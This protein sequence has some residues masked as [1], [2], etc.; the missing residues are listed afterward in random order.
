MKLVVAIDKW[1]V[2]LVRCSASILNW[3][4]AEIEQLDRTAK[5]NDKA[6]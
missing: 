3:T 5:N 6:R 4:Q 2:A 1:A